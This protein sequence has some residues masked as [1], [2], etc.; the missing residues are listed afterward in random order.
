ME[1][2]QP[3]HSGSL[4]PN[5]SHLNNLEKQKKGAEGLVL[6]KGEL[7]PHIITTGCLPAVQFNE[8][9]HSNKLKLCEFDFRVNLPLQGR[10]NEL[11]YD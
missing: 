6:R 8:G 4:R 10:R 5:E 11:H 1:S 9:L 3:V 2:W 7:K